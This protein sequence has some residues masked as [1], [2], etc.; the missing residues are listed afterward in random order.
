MIKSSQ[1]YRGPPYN[2]M[3]SCYDQVR[4]G[5]PGGLSTS[6]VVCIS[7]HSGDDSLALKVDMKNAM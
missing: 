7:L 6:H 5:V 2:I 4:V 1:Y 3:N